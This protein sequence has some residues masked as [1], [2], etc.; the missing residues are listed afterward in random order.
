MAQLI[1]TI[2]D[3]KLPILKKAI[4]LLKGVEKVTI[5][6]DA[7]DDEDASV[8]AVYPAV[9]KGR[10]VSPEVMDMIVGPLP[11][12][13]DFCDREYLKDNNNNK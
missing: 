12:D 3:S 8:S 10:P 9:P 5:G 11:D 13:F 1:V 2:E 4:E 6:N 7:K